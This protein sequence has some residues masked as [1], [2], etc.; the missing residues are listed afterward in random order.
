MQ[1]FE[2]QSRFLKRSLAAIAVLGL[3]AATFVASPAAEAASRHPSGIV[4]ISDRDSPS[5]DQLSDEVYLYEPATRHTSRLTNNAVAE[6]F[7]VISPDGRYLA[8]VD[9]LGISVCALSYRAGSW[10]S[11]EPRVVVSYPSP[12]NGRFAWTPDGQ[13][14]VYSGVDPVDQDGD[15]FIINL[16]DLTPVRNLTQEAPGET[17]AFDGQPT[18]SPDGRFIVYGRTEAGGGNLYRRRIDGSHPVKL[19]A[20]A[21]AAEFGPAYSPDGSHIAFHSNRGHPAN[22]D[23]YVMKARPES[24]FNP[25]IDLTDELTAPDGTPSRERFPSWSPDGRRITFWWHVTPDGF[26]DGEIYTM[27]SDGTHI[28]NITANN[29]DDPSGDIL[30]S[31]GRTHNR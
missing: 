16:F 27:R 13:S 4:F 24:A 7:P 15:V 29:S 20:T 11:G 10:S 28:R 2:Q 14:I 22:F 30:P 23:I 9:G 6:S 3:S 5:P 18:V 12:A 31:W 1:T 17:A 19:T 25:A 21:S 8:Y 26:T